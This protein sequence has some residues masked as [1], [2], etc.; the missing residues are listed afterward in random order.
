MPLNDED[1]VLLAVSEQTPDGLYWRTWC[2]WCSSPHLT[3]PRPGWRRLPCHVPSSPYAALGVDVRLAGV[4][5]GL[6][7]HEEELTCED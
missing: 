2:P 1:V 5:P 3:D 6:P 7:E 4:G